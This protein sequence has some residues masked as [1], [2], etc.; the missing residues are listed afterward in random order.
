MLQSLEAELQELDERILADARMVEA[1]SKWSACM[2][3]AGY[4]QLEQPEDVDA[5]LKGKLEAIVGSPKDA[6]A[7][8]AAADYD[9]A[10][11]AELQREEVAMV[12]ADQ[13]CEKQ[14]IAAVEDKVAEE[15]EAA[16][17]EANAALLA[18]VPGK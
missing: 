11:L 3:A 14:H 17:R 16:F 8:G 13:A 4:G 7:S 18:K 9:R 2:S 10:A 12:A 1:V 15:Y 5:I 6:I